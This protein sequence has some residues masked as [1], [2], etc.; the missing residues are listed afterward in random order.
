VSDDDF[1]GARP[2]TFSQKA[3][4]VPYPTEIQHGAVDGRCRTDLWN[5][6]I[7]FY[8]NHSGAIAFEDI[9]ADHYG[10][11]LHEYDYRK[12]FN[13]L[14]QT[15]RKSD[16]HF[17]FDLV[18]WLVQHTPDGYAEM[19]FGTTS[20]DFNRILARNRAGYRIVDLQVVSITNEAE[21][22]AITTA[23]ATASTPAA[24]H[25][26]NALALFANREQPNFAKS[27]Q[28]SI[29]AAEAATQGI[30]RSQE[31]SWRVA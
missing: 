20:E 12:L 30:G 4:H 28:E 11:P 7:K 22:S 26:K 16:F 9:W 17:L 3:G 10:Q 14:E 8:L 24:N 29:S 5:Y 1:G 27:I 13:R 31:A 23:I 2:P 19:R 15:V 21:L 6:I 18:E 25:L